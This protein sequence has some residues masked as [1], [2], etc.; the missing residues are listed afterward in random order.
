MTTLNLW[1]RFKS[2]YLHSSVKLCTK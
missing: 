1:I 2:L